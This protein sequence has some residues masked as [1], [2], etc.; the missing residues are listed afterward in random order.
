MKILIQAEAFCFGP[1][2]ILARIVDDL[3]LNGFEIDYVINSTQVLVKDRNKISKFINSSK[4]N[5]KLFSQYNYVVVVMDWEFARIAVEAGCKVIFVDA[6]TW[7]WKTIDPIVNN[8]D[9]YL[10]I[11]FSGVE[12][13]VENINNRNAFVVGQFIDPPQFIERSE[14][15][16]F[17]IGGV[18]NPFFDN[19]HASKYA[20]IAI[21]AVNS[22]NSRIYLCGNRLLDFRLKTLG[23]SE[24]DQ[25]LQNSRY[26]IGT[27]GLGHI[28]EC[29]T[30]SIPAL[31]LPPVNDSQ[32]LQLQA[33][34]F[35]SPSWDWISWEE[36]GY[37]I[38]WSLGQAELI[39][40]FEL[41]II[42]LLLNKPALRILQNRISE[43]VNHHNNSLNTNELNQLSRW[44]GFNGERNVS[45]WIRSNS[46]INSYTPLSL[47]PVKNTVEEVIKT[48]DYFFHCTRPENFELILESNTIKAHAK[49]NLYG[50]RLGPH[51][52]TFG[53]L[54]DSA[55]A[56][57]LMD[58]AGCR[59][60]IFLFKS[61]VINQATDWHLS[62]EYNSG[63]LT[64]QCLSPFNPI[65]IN[66]QRLSQANEISIDINISLDDC[67]AIFVPDYLVTQYECIVERYG[68]NIDVIGFNIPLEVLEQVSNIQLS[69]LYS[70]SSPF[71]LA[72]A[73]Y[74]Y[75]ELDQG[76]LTVVERETL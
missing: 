65:Q 31:F 75:G 4:L 32:Y 64:H 30:H 1:A 51:G 48:F 5:S 70:I 57:E 17:S 61:E 9:C 26:F 68:L 38:D 35:R 42:S 15:G 74:K 27:S 58:L 20:K 41:S 28:T 13:I 18:T 73:N 14:S 21:D 29:I 62:P 56:Q 50:D 23:K 10:A 60:P 3:Y 6:L 59:F 66:K 46:A 45:S 76:Y 54:T 25:Y 33:I 44:W 47:S 63:K 43:F 39:E 72:Y 22:T 55:N 7:F 19:F 34:N 16:M 8:F 2:S 12:R 53:Q 11:N 24:F 40:T 37:D 36:L 71:I 69:N 52:S 67:L 49:P